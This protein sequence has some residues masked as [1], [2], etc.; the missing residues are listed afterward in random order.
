MLR[1]FIY[2]WDFKRNTF[3]AGL[4]L[5]VDASNTMTIV[6]SSHKLKEIHCFLVVFIILSLQLLL[7]FTLL[8]F[9]LVLLL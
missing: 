4:V 2:C 9:A 6:V 5:L 7:G 1:V 8:Y 3:A